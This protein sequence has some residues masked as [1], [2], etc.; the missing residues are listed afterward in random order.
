MRSAIGFI[1]AHA[2]PSYCT[3]T[4][5]A[6]LWLRLPEVAVTVTVYVPAG[7][8]GAGD[9]EDGEGGQLP[10]PQPTRSPAPRTT[11]VTTSETANRRLHWKNIPNAN[12]AVTHTRRS[13]SPRNLGSEIVAAVLAAVV[14]TDTVAEPLPPLESRKEEVDRLHVGAGLTPGVIVQLKFTVPRN[15]A[16]ATS[17]K[18]K[19]A[20]FPALTVCDVGEPEAGLIAKSL[21]ATPIPESVTVCGLPLA[22]STMVKV[23]VL[24][25]DTVGVKVM[26]ISQEVADDRGETQLFDSEKPLP[27]TDIC[28]KI[29]GAGAVRRVPDEGSSV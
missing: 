23:P 16:P 15:E 2:A 24:V 28:V 13:G 19:L 6:V 29:S 17:A 12:N 8:P 11:L 7:V 26:C 20:D 4:V 27:E 22:L 10:P 14:A 9:C 3:T 1:A 18:L 21:A 25:P 5:S